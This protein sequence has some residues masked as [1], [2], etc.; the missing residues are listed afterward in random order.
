MFFIAE[1]GINHNGDVEAAKK[2][3]KIAKEK[4]FNAVKF[5]K[6][7]PS[8]GIPEFMKNR[9]RETPWGYI[10][11]PKYREYVEF[12]AAEYD[13]IQWYCE[14]IG[15]DWFASAWDLPSFEFLKDYELKYNKIA[16]PMLTYTPLLEAVAKERKPTFISTGMSTFKQIDAAV[17]IF[18]DNKCPFTLMH[19]VGIYPCPQIK[20]NIR[21]VRTLK[22]RYKCPVGYSG[23]EVDLLPTVLAIVM[24]AEA[25]ERHVTLDRA[26]WGTDQVSSLES[27]GQ[28]LLIRDSNL[29]DAIL[30]DGMTRCLPE[31][32]KKAKQLRWWEN[33]DTKMANIQ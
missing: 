26:M 27:R 6:R 8:I 19:A 24:G 33:G 5:Q 14:E 11:Y 13:D 29:V 2:M 16:S 10:S 31:E 17:E 30:G 25:I 7:D 15:I 21:M 20:C 3:I 4:G 12:E 28:E 32:T 18:R 23:H 1:I 22:E 9:M